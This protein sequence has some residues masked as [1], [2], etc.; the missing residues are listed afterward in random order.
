MDISPCLHSL[1]SVTRVI[2]QSDVAIHPSTDNCKSRVPCSTCCQI[3][4]LILWVKMLVWRCMFYADFIHYHCQRL[5]MDLAPVSVMLFGS[6]HL[7]L[8]HYYW[9][10]Y[11]ICQLNQLFSNSEAAMR[12]TML[13]WNTVWPSWST[14]LLPAKWKRNLQIYF[15][16]D[17]Q[18]CSKSPNI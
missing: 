12:S 2:C 14:L 3:L 18:Q 5:D 4:M 13:S 1:I 15:C 10:W 8:V 9:Y 6:C 17:I 7:I 16:F 11:T